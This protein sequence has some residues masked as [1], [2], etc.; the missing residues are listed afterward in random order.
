MPQSTDPNAPDYVAPVKPVD[1]K[2]HSDKAFRQVSDDMHKYKGE[3]QELQN[4]IDAMKAEQAEET[5][6]ALE[7]NSQ[8]EELYNTELKRNDELQ[9][10]I[11]EKDTNFLKAQKLAAVKDKLGQFKKPEYNK[12]IDTTRIIV[13]NDGNVDQSTVDN[14]VNR[15]KQEYP[16]LIKA[17]VASELLNESPE[18]GKSITKSL[19]KMSTAERADTRRKL[20]EDRSKQ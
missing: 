9:T 20:I 17:K 15:L 1:E 12:F 16:E 10:Q 7:K 19:V 14:E 6:K 4:K 18:S 3:K 8:F 5:R 13:D 2:T 11:T